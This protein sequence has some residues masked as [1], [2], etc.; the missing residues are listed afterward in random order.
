LVLGEDE[1]AGDRVVVKRLRED[2]PQ[3]EVGRERLAQWLADWLA[4]LD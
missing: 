4:G 3:E 1:L 2:L